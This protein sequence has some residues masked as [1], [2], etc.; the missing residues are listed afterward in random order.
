[1]IEVLG[2]KNGEKLVPTPDDE[3]PKDP[4]SENMAFLKGEPTKAFIYQD[5]DA[6]IA[7]HTTFMKDPMIAATMGQNPQAQTMMAAIQAHISEHLGFMYR[8]KIEEQMGVPLPPPNE[9]LPEDVEVQLSKLIADASAQLLQKN[10]AEAQQKQAQ[11][12][13]QDPLIQMQQ[14]ELKI[15]GDEVARK[16]AKDQADMALAQARLQID[17]QRIQAEGQREAMRLQSQQKQ[18]EQKIKADVITK[19]TRK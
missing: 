14:A 19:M 8:R 2:I 5:Q 4:V 7:V 10:T 6:H 18:T 12:Q 17:A 9:K 13:A 16:A 11:Q 15:K 3:D 1:M